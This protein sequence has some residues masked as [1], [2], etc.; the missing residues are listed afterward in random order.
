MEKR[1]EQKIRQLASE[2]KQISK[3]KKDD[4]PHYEYEEVYW[5]VYGI[6][7]RSARGVKRMI[8]TRLQSLEQA[9]QKQ[10]RTKII[11]EVSELVWDLYDRVKKNQTKLEKIRE[12]LDPK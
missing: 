7:N 12:I 4:F 11:E 9:G 8:A 1:E 2:G 6:G 5:V 10:E 3:I